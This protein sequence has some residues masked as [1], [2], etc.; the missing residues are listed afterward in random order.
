RVLDA[1]DPSPAL[2]RTATW[3]VVAWNRAATLLLTDYT[4]LEPS[5]RNI[6]RQ[7][8]LNPEARAA[9]ADWMSVA[10]FLVA[11]FRTETLKAG[12]DAA[13]APLVDEL[14]RA[15]PEFAALWHENA[16]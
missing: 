5:E 16:V 6:L 7:M 4:A 9:Q 13:I 8:F 10:R 14:S 11:T 3:S 12:A 15:S 1:L 2:I